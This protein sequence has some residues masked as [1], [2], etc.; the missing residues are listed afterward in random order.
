[1]FL[2][3]MEE[4]KHVHEMGM[5]HPH[6]N[7]KKKRTQ[8]HKK[9]VD[10]MSEMTRTNRNTVILIDGESVLMGYDHIKSYMNYNQKSVKAN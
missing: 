3:H 2:V 8:L 7:N 4:L 5:E 9:C 6:T 1:M 10:Y